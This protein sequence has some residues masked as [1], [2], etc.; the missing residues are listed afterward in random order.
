MVHQISRETV[1]RIEELVL[2]QCLCT[3]WQADIQRDAARIS[4]IRPP[5]NGN[6]ERSKAFPLSLPIGSKTNLA[7]IFRGSFG[8]RVGEKGD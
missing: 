7:M 2:G 6:E 3:E 1:F 8:V 5:R 4:E